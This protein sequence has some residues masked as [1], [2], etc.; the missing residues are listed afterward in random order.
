M[1]PKLAPRRRLP[2]GLV[3]TLEKTI[4][5]A[6]AT[7]ANDPLDPL[8]YDDRGVAR[9]Q[10]ALEPIMRELLPPFDTWGLKVDRS[11][12]KIN[13]NIVPPFNVVQFNV[14]TPENP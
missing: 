2:N 3:K 9:L 11:T 1:K 5:A 12:G 6:I 4:G 14:K 10:A 7:I 13:I 8:Y